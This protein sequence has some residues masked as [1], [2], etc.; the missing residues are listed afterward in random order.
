MEGY[1]LPSK[2]KIYDGVQVNPHVELRSMT[3]RDEMKRLSPSTTPLKTL[4][5]IV[6]GCCVEK[7]AIHVYDMALGD[8]E[9]LLHKLRIVTYGEKYNLTCKCPECYK[10]IDAEADLGQMEIQEFD[11][12]A[13]NSARTF[14][15]P[16]CG[17]TITLRIQSPRL[18]EETEVKVKE[19]QRKYKG[20]SI[21]FE[22]MCKLLC[23]IETVDGV[24]LNQFDLE[25]IINNLSARDMQKI[26]NQ[27]DALGRQVG[28]KNLIFVHCPHCQSE[29]ATFFRYGP[30]FFRPT[31]I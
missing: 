10:T 21:D 9:Y 23:N 20:A 4:A 13:Y 6:E 3:A 19:M 17:K 12:D 11:I 2:G 8:Y 1:E 27:I 26:L 31:N 14:V 30:E 15:L 22:T 28:V 5:D 16:T 24:K 18:L 7:P 29:V 25:N